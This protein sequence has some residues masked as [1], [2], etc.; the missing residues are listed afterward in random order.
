M[1]NELQQLARRHELD[2]ETLISAYIGLGDKEEAFALLEKE[3]DAHST[4]L[5]S[6]K[7]N[8]LYDSLRSDPRFADLLRR[9]RLS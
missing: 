3:F 7:V 8:P 4:G 1:L 6:L 5:T 9:V 2:P